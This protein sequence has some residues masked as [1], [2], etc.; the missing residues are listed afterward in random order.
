MLPAMALVVASAM[1]VAMD[2]EMAVNNLIL[3]LMITFWGKLSNM[4]RMITY[5]KAMK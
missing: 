2:K 1:A 5:P 3:G 4:G